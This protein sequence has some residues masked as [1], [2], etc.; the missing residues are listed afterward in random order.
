MAQ[1]RRGTQIVQISTNFIG[2]R[3]KRKGVQ[4]F[5]E[6]EEFK[7]RSQEPGGVRVGRAVDRRGARLR[8]VI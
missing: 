3:R 6:F 8:L 7:S 4:E 2:R 1:S 5:K